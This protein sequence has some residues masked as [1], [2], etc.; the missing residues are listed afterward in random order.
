MSSRESSEV[1]TAPTDDPKWVLARYEEAKELIEE[2]R[3]AVQCGDVSLD[4]VLLELVEDFRAATF[5]DRCTTLGPDCGCNGASVGS[6][7]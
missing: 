3:A 1:L 7:S 5:L 4:A 6:A 2:L